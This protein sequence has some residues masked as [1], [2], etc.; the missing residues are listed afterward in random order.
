MTEAEAPSIRG[1]RVALV[2]DSLFIR[3]GL[4]RVLELCGASVVAQAPEPVAGMVELE[5]VRPDAVILDVRMPPS[6][7]NEGIL[8]AELIRNRHPSIG[9]LVLAQDAEMRHVR[10][11]LDRHQRGIGYMLKD[12]VTDQQEL[13]AALQRI[14]AGGTA[15]DPLVVDLL[16]R[17]RRRHGDSDALAELTDRELTVLAM[18]AEGLSNAGIADRLSLGPRTV[19]T[20]V[21][22]VFGKLAL[23]PNTVEHRRVRAVVEYLQARPPAP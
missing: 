21:K 10:R 5:R 19:E 3:E 7:T 20:H 12:R 23:A 11:L 22:S 17:S 18:M 1:L 13:V 16:M 9:I 8:A 2:D 14:V 6:H 15:V 4:T